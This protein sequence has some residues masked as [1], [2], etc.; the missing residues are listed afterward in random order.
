[1]T[2]GSSTYDIVGI[3]CSFLGSCRMCLNISGRGIVRGGGVG[4]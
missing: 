3:C 1:M 2:Y 4:E